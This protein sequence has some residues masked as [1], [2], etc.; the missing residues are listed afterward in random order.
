MAVYCACCHRREMKI[1][2]SRTV[3]ATRKSA[4]ESVLCAENLRIFLE[5]TG[6]MRKG[7]VTY[8]NTALLEPVC[9][10]EVDQMVVYRMLYLPC[11]CR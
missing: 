11:I 5:N 10:H 4:N 7:T 2:L 9:V 3:R 8:E 6:V 1:L